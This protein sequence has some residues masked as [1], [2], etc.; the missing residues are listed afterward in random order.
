MVSLKFM[1][2]QLFIC[3]NPDTLNE[4]NSFIKEGIG[5]FMI[6]KGGEIN[7]PELRVL[8]GNSKNDLK[9]FVKL[10][11][12]N[13]KIEN[14]VPLFIAIDGEGGIFFNRLKSFSDYKS[15]R[16]Y[17][18]KFE[19][20]NDLSYFISEV[21]N[22]AKLMN[23]IGL[24][25]NFAPL[26]D[27]AKKGYKG[28]VAS[29]K[30]K[31]YNNE[32]NESEIYS[33]NR[34]YSDKSEIVKTLGITAA[35]SFQEHNI[36]S[37]IKHFLSYGE[38]I[39]SNN[40]HNMLPKLKIDKSRLNS[41]LDIYKVA[42]EKD[43]WALMKGHELTFLDEKFPVSL[44]IKTEKYLKTNLN[45]EGISVVDELNMGAIKEFYG[46]DYVKK[47]ACKAVMTND[48]ILIS[49]PETFIPMRDAIVKKALN[50]IKMKLKIEN[51]YNKILKL[52]KKIKL[53]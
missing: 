19:K 13:S 34:A 21:L 38:L 6:G 43:V 35:L 16:F 49:H 51:S 18:E 5:G 17:G 23:E 31:I 40:P 29:E 36:V 10:L 28:Y 9:K 3:K 45:F 30:I 26:V 50:N 11:N 4:I 32:L 46:K 47:A 1:V 44:S 48:I 27:I 24:N 8:E 20:D 42:F 22:F 39:M 25:M 7:S 14:M 41:Q 33:S 2:S 37:T 53:L 12:K 15:P 52:K